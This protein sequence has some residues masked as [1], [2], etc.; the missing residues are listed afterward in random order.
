M[1]PFTIEE[2]AELKTLIEELLIKG[3]PNIGQV[4]K[5]ADPAKVKRYEELKAKSES[6]AQTDTADE[7]E[8]GD[9]TKRTDAPETADTV[10]SAKE[11]D[12]DQPVK[13]TADPA[14]VKQPISPAMLA[15]LKNVLKRTGGYRKGMTAQQLKE[16]RELVKHAGL[17]PDAPRL[18]QDV[19][20]SQFEISSA[21]KL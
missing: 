11:S 13:K 4:K 18:P 15:R 19:W 6:A 1:S 21:Q 17:N 16:A 3:G 2:Q 14:K 9:E 20:P 12:A 5:T 10:Q 7:Q 8:T